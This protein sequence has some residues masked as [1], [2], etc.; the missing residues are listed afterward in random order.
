VTSLICDRRDRDAFAGLIGELPQ[1]WDL[2]VDCIGFEVADAQ[3]DIDLF[4]DRA[5]RFV[6]VSTDFVYEPGARQVPQGEESDYFQAPGSYGGNKR[7]CELEFVNADTGAMG[8]TV[9]RPCHI[10][11]PGSQLGCL[12]MHSRDPDLIATLRAGMPLRL[13]GG[14]TFLQQP[15]LARDLADLILSVPGNEASPGEI[16]CAA[17]PD[18]IESR[19]YYRI[20]ADHL[21]LSLAVEEMAVQPYLEANPNAV[22][23]LCH[24]VYDLTK[25]SASGLTVPSTSMIQGLGEHVDSL[26]AG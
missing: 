5:D 23:F 21:G 4:C 8:W 22:N 6:F 10:Y 14:G 25:L 17:G 1:S 9:L 11:G 3:Q 15:I 26:L 16:Y 18:V 12:P 24:R 20:I 2:A 7:L 13:A 19:A